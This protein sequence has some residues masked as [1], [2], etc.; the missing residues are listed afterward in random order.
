MALAALAALAALSL[1]AVPAV[2]LTTTWVSEEDDVGGPVVMRPVVV[3]I[4]GVSSVVMPVCSVALLREGTLAPALEGV[5][6][7]VRT[8]ED[9]EEIDAVEDAMGD[10]GVT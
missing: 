1:V 7:G 10:E 2:G 8:A 9:E 5:V 3:D 6:D 4:F